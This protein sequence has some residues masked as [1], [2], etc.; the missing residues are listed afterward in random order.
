MN[1]RLFFTQ[2]A[3]KTTYLSIYLSVKAFYGPHI[4]AA[5][6]PLSS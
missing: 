3:T 5:T 2:N 4:F 1:T 6:G